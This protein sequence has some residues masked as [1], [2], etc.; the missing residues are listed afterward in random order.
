MLESNLFSLD[1]S[2]FLVWNESQ[3]TIIVLGVLIY[4]YIHFS[5]I[6]MFI[7]YLSIFSPVYCHYL[8]FLPIF[9]VLKLW[10][11]FLTHPGESDAIFGICLIDED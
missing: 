10:N 5:I 3:I 6:F 2:K 8:P 4:I 7:I 11:T 1:W 9:K